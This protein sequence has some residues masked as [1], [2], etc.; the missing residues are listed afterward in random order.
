MFINCITNFC[1]QF[2][3]DVVLQEIMKYISN[4]NTLSIVIC[5]WLETVQMQNEFKKFISIDVDVNKSDILINCL[6]LKGDF[7]YSLI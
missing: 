6:K 2:G 4:G 5:N 7:T 3:L 1:F